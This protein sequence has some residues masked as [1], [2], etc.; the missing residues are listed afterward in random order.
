M[1][2]YFSPIYFLLVKTYSYDV[3]RIITAEEDFF[4][5]NAVIMNRFLVE[6]FNVSIKLRHYNKY[7]LFQE[8]QLHI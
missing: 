6:I 2:Q 4:V 8:R 5:Q 3:Y 7:N 1:L